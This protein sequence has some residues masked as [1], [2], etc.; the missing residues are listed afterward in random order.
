MEGPPQ[1]ENS[2]V[3][4]EFLEE[5]AGLTI[6]SDGAGN[7]QGA[8]YG[9]VAFEGNRLCHSEKGPLGRVCPYEAELYAVRAA[10]SWLMS[11]PHRLKGNVVLYTDSKSVE[12]VLKS[13]RIKST[14]VQRVLDLIIKV[15]EACSFDIRWIRGHSGNEG[16]E[17]ADGL[18]KEAAREIQGMRVTEVTLKDVKHFIQC[19][20]AKI[21]QTRWQNHMGAARKFIREVKP[22]KMKF[23]KKDVQEK[24]WGSSSKPLLVMGYLA[25]ISVSGKMMLIKY[26]KCCLE[27]E[28][29]TAWHLW[30]ECPALTSTKQSLPQG[31][32][33]PMEVVV[34]RFF[35]TEPV[36]ELMELRTN[37]LCIRQTCNENYGVSPMSQKDGDQRT[38]KEAWQTT[39]PWG[40]ANNQPDGQAG[41][42]CGRPFSCQ[43]CCLNRKI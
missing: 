19:K 28:L 25:T 23:M 5:E 30:S 27:E 14:A 3:E 39:G 7:S 11:N 36:K 6:Y 13:A 1:R 18:A 10:L 17:L 15:K 41:G 38:T 20:T 29:E 9:F 21:W 31:R 22:N 8:G 34:L 35:K 43:I 12:L 4:W 16:Q 24:S 26:V 33:V 40:V 37:S 42:G 2:W 32:D